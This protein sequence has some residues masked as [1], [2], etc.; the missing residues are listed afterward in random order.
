[1][2]I[3]TMTPCRP[4]MLRAFYDWLNDN[5]LTPHLVVDA[6]LPGVQV[7]FEFVQD[8]KIILNIASRAVGNLQLGN[9]SITFNARF[10][11]RP[12]LVIVPLYAVQ[13]IYAR[14]NGVGTMFAP[15]AAYEMIPESEDTVEQT[16]STGGLSV[17]SSEEPAE[18]QS[19][20]TENGDAPRPKSKGRPSLR[21]VE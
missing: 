8:G 14:E 15:E 1:M 3:V 6:T 9:E 2:S 7:P 16:D 5:E 20:S 17:V 19:D 12:H 21:I 13:E 10:S 4:Y 18:Q 11:G